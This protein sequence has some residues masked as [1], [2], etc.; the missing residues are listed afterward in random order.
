MNYETFKKVLSKA[1]NIAVVISVI[2][3][4]IGTAIIVNMLLGIENK[5]TVSI[6]IGM[7]FGVL[8]L[9][10]GVIAFKRMLSDQ[11]QARNDTHPILKAIKEGDRGYLMWVYVEQINTT[12]GHDGPKVGTSQNVNYFTRD[13]KGK[14]KT[15]MTGK[16]YT[17]AEIIAYLSTEFD[18]PYLDYSDKTREAMN[19]YFGTSGLKKL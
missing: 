15:I 13:C 16:N 10:L 17:A 11:L 6:V 19:T 14:G 1:N 5:K 8:L 18:I 2:L 4:L 3:V 7:F 12:L 9:I